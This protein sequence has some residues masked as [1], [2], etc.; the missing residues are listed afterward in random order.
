MRISFAWVC[1]CLVKILVM[2]YTLYI[3]YLSNIFIKA[4][5]VEPPPE[6]LK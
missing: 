3:L 2:M 4:H 1:F 5:N 6:L